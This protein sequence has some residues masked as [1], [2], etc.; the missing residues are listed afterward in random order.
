MREYFFCVSI[1]V[2]MYFF[3]EYFNVSTFFWRE[4]FF[5]VST[6]ACVLFAWVLS[7]WVLILREYF[8]REY[9]LYDYFFFA[10]VPFWCEYFLGSVSVWVF[11]RW[12][13]FCVGTFWVSTFFAW[14]LILRINFSI[15]C[16]LFV[17]I[18]QDGDKKS[19]INRKINSQI[20]K[21]HLKMIQLKTITYFAS[22]SF[23]WVFFAL[24]FAR[25]LLRE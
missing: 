25:V 4:H 23:A 20:K 1:L 10:W 13:I 21:P 17:L 5:G 2:L 15:Y 11:L 12:C 14:V 8:L 18:Y 3:R 16:G 22:E 7:A 19:A 9:F 24:V 6:F